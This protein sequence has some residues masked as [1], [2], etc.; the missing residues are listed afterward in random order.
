MPTIETTMQQE[1]SSLHLRAGQQQV[2]THILSEGNSHR[3]QNQFI[4][5]QTNQTLNTA[6]EQNSDILCTFPTGYGKSLCYII[7]A[8]VLAAPC[9]VVSPLCSLI[10]VVILRHN[11]PN[12][13]LPQ[14]IE[15][16]YSSNRTSAPSSTPARTHRSAPSTSA[17]AAQTAPQKSSPSNKP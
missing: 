3:T 15:A 10:Q 14:Q 11:A 17:Q 4:C 1:F 2:I 8:H 9:I 12:I 6:T 5:T 13:R 7:P 16:A